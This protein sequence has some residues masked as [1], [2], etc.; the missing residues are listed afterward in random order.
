M[1]E[2]VTGVKQ[3]KRPCGHLWN[4]H[5]MDLILVNQPKLTKKPLNTTF[6]GG[7]K[8]GNLGEIGLCVHSSWL[9]NK[10]DSFV[11]EFT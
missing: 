2:H 9:I 3:G 6:K 4:G 5:D 1:V 11:E 10:F 7:V 8:R